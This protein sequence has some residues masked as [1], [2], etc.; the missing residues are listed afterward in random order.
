MLRQQPLHHLVLLIDDTA[1][2]AVDLTGSLLRIVAFLL[3]R[4]DLHK[5]G[6]ALTIERDRPQLAAHPVGLD[7]TLGN[8]RGLDQIV[9]RASGGLAKDQLFRNP[10]SQ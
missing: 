10:P 8:V 5:E 6:L 9:L 3:R 1:D 2:F 7:H 4:L